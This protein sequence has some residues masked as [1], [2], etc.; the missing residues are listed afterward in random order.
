[1]TSNQT[2]QRPKAEACIWKQAGVVAGKTC[3]HH[4]DCTTCKYDFAMGKQVVAGKHSSWQDMLRTRDSVER[5]CRHALTGRAGH[6]T[7][8]M[9]YNCEHCGFDQLLE[10]NLSMLG[11]PAPVRVKNIKGFLLAE[12]HCFHTGHTWARLDDGG[13][14]RIGM[15]DFV[16][17]M[18]GGPDA[19]DLPLM[20]QELNRDRPG[21]GIRR[22]SNLADILSPVNGVIT[23]VNPNVTS[24][25]DLPETSPYE[26]GWLFCVHHSDLK[27]AMK[28]LMR[29][30]DT[31]AWLD[32]DISA[33]ETM[34]E[35]TAGPLSADGGF[36]VR[37][38]YGAMPALGWNNLTRKFLTSKR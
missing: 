8:P 37:D 28:P 19:F 7:C 25:P 4:H 3:T 38:I 11:R 35:E 20:G 30:S 18:L 14:I 1:M 22:G 29:G 34:I 33:L 5:T 2:N 6:R 23:Q 27:E 24:R 26:D 15:D 12:D 17:K 21:W 31:S 9:N 36:L 10:D 32:G 16:F 13:F